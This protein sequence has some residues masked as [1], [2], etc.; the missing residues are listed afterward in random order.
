[1]RHVSHLFFFLAPLFYSM[2][3]DPYRAYEVVLVAIVF[4]VLF[5]RSRMARID[6]FEFRVV[7]TYSLLLVI[8]QSYI[9]NGDLN[10]GFKFMIATLGAFMP[11]WVLRSSHWNLPDIM[12]PLSRAINVLFVIVVLSFFSS[13]FLGIGEHYEGGFLGRRAFGYLGDSF[14]P[15][16]IF[17]IVFYSLERRWAFAFLS[18]V[19]LLM[20]GGKAGIVMVTATLTFYYIFISKSVVARLL[21]ISVTIL[22]FVLPVG[23]DDATQNIRNFEYSL[24]NRL[25][26]FQVGWEYFKSNPIVGIGINQALGNVDYDAALLARSMGVNN[27]F[28]VHQIHNAYIRSLA[29]T[30]IIGFGLLLLLV[31]YWVR[32]GM[33]AVLCARSLAPCTERSF[34]IATGIWVI[35]FVL[36]YQTTGWFLSGH[37]QLTWLLV[38]STYAT[39]LHD[40]ITASR[41]RET[42]QRARTIPRARNMISP[43]RETAWHAH[44]DFR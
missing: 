34:L 28:P 2:D 13:F 20:T 12:T 33:R 36:G 10:F 18:F 23:I 7:V 27:F 19:C 9:D 37:P 8:Q 1:M 39:I 14:T 38:F 25:L 43:T 41:R 40:R 3:N 22:L 6:L 31:F 15:V 4:S 29:E 16:V 44:P 42:A 26:S 30:G 21:F 24:N 35:C 32:V 17:L 5:M 11:F